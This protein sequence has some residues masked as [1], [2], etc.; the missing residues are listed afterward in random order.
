[1]IV[2]LL[3]AL[4]STTQLPEMFAQQVT[5]Q[6]AAVTKRVNK[7]RVINLNGSSTTGLI[8]TGSNSTWSATKLKKTKQQEH[9]SQT[10]T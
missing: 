8:A 10:S 6:V 2:V 3:L 7:K 4:L 9:K 1:M 5:T